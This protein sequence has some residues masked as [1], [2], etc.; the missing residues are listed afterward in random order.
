M[1]RYRRH[2]A[3]ADSRMDSGLCVIPK[4]GL[5]RVTVH[6]RRHGTDP[7]GNSE[8]S[9]THVWRNGICAAP[10]DWSSLDDAAIRVPFER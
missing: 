10:A 2:S 3:P 6:A 5:P 1:R 8:E 9:K 7:I 4:H